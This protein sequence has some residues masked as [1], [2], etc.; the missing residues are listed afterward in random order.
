MAKSKRARSPRLRR[1]GGSL[2]TTLPAELAMRQREAAPDLSRVARARLAMLDWH[3]A[4]G[5]VV[6][7]T[8]RHFG[9]S[10]PTV[11]RWLARYDRFR[12]ESLEDRSDAPRRRRRPTWSVATVEAVRAVR[13]VREAYPRW[14]KDKFVVLLRRDGIVVSTSMVGRIL[15]GLRRRGALR[16]PAGRRIGVRRRTFGSAVCRP[17]ASRLVDRRT[18]RPRRARHARHPAGL[19]RRPSSSSRPA[20][21]FPLGRRRARPAGDGP[22][23]RRGPRAAGR[24]DALPGPGD[25]H[26]Q[27]LGVHT[28]SSRRPARPAASG[29][30]VLP[31][32]S[33]KLHGSVER[34][35]R[36]HTEEFYEVTDAPAGAHRPTD[37]TASLGNDAQHH[38]AP[39]GSRLSHPGRIP[40]FAASRWVT[41]VPNEYTDL[42]RSEGHCYT[43]PRPAEGRFSAFRLDFERRPNPPPTTSRRPPAARPARRART[44]QTSWR[45]PQP[46]GR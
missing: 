40:G 2:R 43:P 26:R 1:C 42:P 45:T 36:T 25:Q 24:A 44:A 11:Y 46:D 29:V 5:A 33:P 41:D 3:T 7:R 32:R 34:A 12:L 31:P 10:R 35:N 18:G 15:A 28:P 17:Q 23:R 21:S 37:R 19:D 9:F 13:A 39:S 4:H 8:A 14:G 38:P 30:F 6:A 20:T 16:E 27:R 22:G